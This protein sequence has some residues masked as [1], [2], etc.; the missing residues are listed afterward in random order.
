M[1]ALLVPKSSGK[2]C[3]PMASRKRSISSLKPC[4]AAVALALPVSHGA[5]TA[6]EF[7]ALALILALVLADGVAGWKRRAIEYRLLAKLCRKQ[8]VLAPLGWVVPR[9]GAWATSGPE[10][11]PEADA[12]RGDHGA[13][14]AWLFSAWLREASLSTGALDAARVEAVRAAAVHDLI[15]DQ[16]AYHTARRAQSHRASRRLVQAGE[17]L[18][19]VVLVLV[20]AK[21]WLLWGGSDRPGLLVVLG[22]AGAILPALSAALVGIRAYAE[23]ELLAEQSDT[24]LKA[25]RAAKMRIL[26]LDCAA[27]LAS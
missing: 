12:P 15:E 6:V 20:A 21:R 24:M 27:P 1:L 10:P 14:V 9:V 13:W 22:L 26:L 4:A 16:I 3:S 7:A 11:P 19:L 17:T 23:L 18:F 25:M 2:Q 5:A 8:Q